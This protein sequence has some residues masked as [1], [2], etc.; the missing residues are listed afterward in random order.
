MV[1]VILVMLQQVAGSIAYLKG[2]AKLQST[3]KKVTSFH[4][5]RKK[6]IISVP[7]NIKRKRILPFFSRTRAKVTEPEVYYDVRL[8]GETQVLLGVR[9]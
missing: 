8:T 6:K 5:F 9:S 4:P 1:R 3:K 2:C 7:E